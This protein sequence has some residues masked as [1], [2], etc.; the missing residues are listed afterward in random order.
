MITTAN[1]IPYNKFYSPSKGKVNFLHKIVIYFSQK[2]HKIVGQFSQKL[3]KIV[4][5]IIA[6]EKAFPAGKAQSYN[7]L[8]THITSID[9]QLELADFILQLHCHL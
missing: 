4:T 7:I 2:L 6:K 3:H 9:L 5:F 1:P 8:H